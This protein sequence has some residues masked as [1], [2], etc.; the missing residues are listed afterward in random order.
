MNEEEKQAIE[1]LED[2]KVYNLNKFISDK[3][4]RAIVTVIKLINKQQKEIENRLDEINCLYKFISI[5]EERIDELVEIN[6]KYNDLYISKDKIKGKIKELK[7]KKIGASTGI[8]AVQVDILE[9]LL[10]E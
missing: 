8:F 3:E 4:A 1:T 9:E 5:R 6:E 2:L 10:G 7:N